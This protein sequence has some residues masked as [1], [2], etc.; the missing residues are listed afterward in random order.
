M[1]FLGELWFDE[2]GISDCLDGVWGISC[3]GGRGFWNQRRFTIVKV[4]EIRWV[5][6]MRGYG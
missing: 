1:V 5:V 6:R 4:G 3:T 2:K